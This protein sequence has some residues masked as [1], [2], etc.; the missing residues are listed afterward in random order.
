MWKNE[1]KFNLWEKNEVKLEPIKQ[2]LRSL[3]WFEM[4]WE[5]RQN[6]KSL[7]RLTNVQKETCF[8]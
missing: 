2:N 1:F 8:L 5:I 3:S 4:D 7:E 6:W